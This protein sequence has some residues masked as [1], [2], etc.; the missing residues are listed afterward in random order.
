M[1]LST[2]FPVQDLIFYGPKTFDESYKIPSIEESNAY[3]RS[4]AQKHYENFTVATFFLPRNLRTHFYSLYAYCR[5]ADDLG[6]EVSENGESL[7]LLDW[8]EAQLD[9]LYAGDAPLH[10]VFIAL[11]RTVEEFQIPKSLFS[12][13]LTAFRQDRIVHEYKTRAELLDYCKNSA[14]PVGRLILYLAGTTDSV[15]FQMSDAIC[16][17][18]QLAN[19]WQDTARDWREKRRIYIPEEDRR[20]FGYSKSDFEQ[21]RISPDFQRLMEE[22]TAWAESFFEAGRPLVNR[23]PRRFRLE[24]RLFHDGGRA[25]LKSVRKIN[26]R[27]WERRPVIGKGVKIRLLLRALL[28]L[29]VR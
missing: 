4:L 27:V 16:T 29:L 6:D 13:L 23:V 2:G 25:I 18:L 24:I 3:C 26:F 28:S 12:D 15:S 19:F 8:W 5:W 7:L 14:N 22:E 11:K 20:R 1:Q 17:G 10:P 9:A 21:E